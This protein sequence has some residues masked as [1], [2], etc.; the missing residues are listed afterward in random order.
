VSSTPVKTSE[1]L[2]HKFNVINDGPG[3]MPR[4]DVQVLLPLVN[5][6]F[7]LVAS[8]SVTVS[9]HVRPLSDLIQRRSVTSNAFLGLLVSRDI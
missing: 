6:S 1:T 3:L 9:Q 8:Q 7:G 4:V 2:M 5:D